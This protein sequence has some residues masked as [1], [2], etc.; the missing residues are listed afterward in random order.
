[1]FLDSSNRNAAPIQNRSRNGAIFLSGPPATRTTS[2][3]A[4]RIS[5]RTKR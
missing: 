1:M 2:R 4:A 3:D 5:P